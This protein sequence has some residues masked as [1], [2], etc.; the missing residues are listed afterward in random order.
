MLRIISKLNIDSDNDLS[1]V[2][3]QRRSNM[4]SILWMLMARYLCYN[5]FN[6]RSTSSYH[7]ATI[8]SLWTSDTIWWYR[9]VNIGSGNGLF[10]DG[11]KPILEPCKLVKSDIPRYSPERDFTVKPQA[12]VLYTEFENQAFKNSRPIELII[13]LKVSGWYWVK[14]SM[15][16]TLR[17]NKISM[18]KFCCIS[19]SWYDH[20]WSPGSVGFL[21]L[22]NI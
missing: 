10:P 7:N 22:H 8:N 17:G 1:P 21:T 18:S 11:T 20:V 6:T 2:R 3:W 9:A 14:Y 19:S 16:S 12:T 15:L 5:N 4:K 13:F